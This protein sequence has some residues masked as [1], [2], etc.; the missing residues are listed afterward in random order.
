VPHDAKAR[1]LGTGRTR[2]ETLLS[3]GRDVALVPN[4][5]VM[6]GI[7]AARVSFKRFWFDELNCRQGL[8]ALRQYRAEF[9][10]KT[11]T[12]KNHPRHD[13]C[14]HGS[15]AFRYMAMAWKSLQPAEKPKDPIQELL[16]KRT[17]ADVLG[18]IGDDSEE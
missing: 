8:E 15:D 6:D 4:H 1:E 12:F 7:N 17:M 5:T 9:D 3:L 11:K 16:K 18:T 14:S 10:E 13:W 2:V